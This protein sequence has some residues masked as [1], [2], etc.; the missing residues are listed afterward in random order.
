MAPY[1]VTFAQIQ[2]G[3]EEHEDQDAIRDGTMNILEYVKKEKFKIVADAAH[4]ARVQDSPNNDPWYN[5]MDQEMNLTKV[6]DL[7]Y[8]LLFD[9]LL[10]KGKTGAQRDEAIKQDHPRIKKDENLTSINLTF[11]NS[12]IPTWEEPEDRILVEQEARRLR[13][14]S[15]EID[16]LTERLNKLLRNKK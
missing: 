6:C 5:A 12:H 16:L 13:K 14:I 11:L 7:S 8:Y 1:E 4:N 3:D 9:S 2:M 10:Y 15:D